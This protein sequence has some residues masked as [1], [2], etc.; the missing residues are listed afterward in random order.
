MTES[1][2]SRMFQMAGAT[3][4]GRVRKSNQD[5]FLIADH[6]RLLD[7]CC[8]SVEDFDGEKI[9]SGNPGELLI[10][11]DGMGGYQHGAV[12][13]E[14]TIREMAAFVA[15]MRHDATSGAIDDDV[16]FRKALSSLPGKI[17]RHLQIDGKKDLAKAKMGTTLTAAY[18]RWP[19]CYVFHVGD[20]RCYLS[21][22][23]ILKQITHD[24]TIA[25]TYI[26]AGMPE[27]ALRN[28]ASQHTLWNS[29]S[30]SDNEPH[31]D[32]TRIQ[33]KVGDTLVLCSDGLTR[34]LSSDNILQEISSE[35]SAEDKCQRLIKLANDRGGRDNITVVIADFAGAPTSQES[36]GEPLEFELPPNLADTAVM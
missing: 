24:H 28:P 23:G 20:S 5:Q 15:S 27:M 18:I 30:A 3:N 29:I 2:H 21:R 25:Q 19:W 11:A 33:L 16:E 7:V 32:L 36:C 14:I 13:S 4:Q 26:D 6:R 35:L 12:A 9:V 10:V 8:S 17:H 31:P 34:H 22:D 1:Y